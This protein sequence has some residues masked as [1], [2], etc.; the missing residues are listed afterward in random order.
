MKRSVQYYNDEVVFVDSPRI[1]IIITSVDRLLQRFNMFLF[2]L[3]SSGIWEKA[4]AGFMK[5]LER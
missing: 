3:C 5:Q 2:S 4:Y 1:I